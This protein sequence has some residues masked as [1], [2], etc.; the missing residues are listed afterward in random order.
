MSSLFKLRV[1]KLRDRGRIYDFLASDRIANAYQ[2]GDLDEVH[3]AQSTW[4]AALDEQG[5]IEAALLILEG[6]SLPV[7]FSSGSQRG[8]QTLFRSCALPPRFHF[9]IWEGHRGSLESVHQ[10]HSSSHM[11]RMALHR[12]AFKP[13]TSPIGVVALGHLHTADIIEL[14]AHYPDNLFEPYQLGSGLYFGVR[15]GGRL[16][17][18]AGIHVVSAE[19]DLAAIG[20]LVTDP[21][22]RGKGYVTACTNRLLEALFERVSLVTLNA[23]VENEAAVHT[24]ERLGFQHH[25]LYL[26]GRVG[27]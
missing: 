4:F 27:F 9:Q 5:E 15:E 6:L 8:A 17:S 25:L 3:F 13:R 10:L 11:A 14:Y 19:H 23:E 22:C 18:I 12:S 2:I 20:N 1:E 21:T 24:F 26:E 16:V 7:V